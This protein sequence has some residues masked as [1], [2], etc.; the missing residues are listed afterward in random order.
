[1]TRKPQPIRE[2]E[3]RPEAPTPTTRHDGRSPREPRP[4]KVER[5]VMSHAEGSALVSM[6]AHNHHS[7]PEVGCFSSRRRQLTTRPA[8]SKP[9]DR[10]A[11]AVSPTNTRW[12]APLDR[13]R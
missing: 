5:G 2:R 8:G 10:S 13:A 4:F 3:A 1:M 6:W 12:S 9:S 11:D 7:A